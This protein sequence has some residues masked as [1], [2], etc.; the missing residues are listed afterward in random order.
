MRTEKHV[1][2]RRTKL[3]TTLEDI[4]VRTQEPWKLET[5]TR[6]SAWKY[7]L[8]FEQISSYQKRILTLMV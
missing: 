5:L 7:K 2:K 6:G 8:I 1:A 3:I 4:G